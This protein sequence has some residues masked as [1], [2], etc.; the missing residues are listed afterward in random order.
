[1]GSAGPVYIRAVVAG[2]RR[3]CLWLLFTPQVSYCAQC[4]TAVDVPC[5]HVLRNTVVR[6]ITAHPSYRPLDQPRSVQGFDPNSKPNMFTWQCA[7]KTLRLRYTLLHANHGD[8]SM[9][10]CSLRSAA[11]AASIDGFILRDPRTTGRKA[12]YL[13]N[14]VEPS[15]GSAFQQM[16]FG[17]SS[18]SRYPLSTPSYF[19]SVQ[20]EFP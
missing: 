7:T 16:L 8:E 13:W 18:L 20:T 6:T 19:L 3:Y 12:W 5:D 15:V 10:N 14:D 9:S 11:F 1:M 2:H 4:F 17:R